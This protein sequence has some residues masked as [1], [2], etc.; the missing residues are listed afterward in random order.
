MRTCLIV[1]LGL[2]LIAPLGCTKSAPENADVAELPDWL[3]E[4]DGP[5]SRKRASS[6]NDSDEEFDSAT[7]N[8]ESR[9]KPGKLELKLSPGDRFP[10]TKTVDVELAQVSLSGTPEISRRRLELMLLIEVADRRADRTQLRVRYD[11]SATPAKWPA[12]SWNTIRALPRPRFRSPCGC[13]TTWFATD[14]PSG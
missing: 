14:S 13:I 5:A 10:L 8:D 7:A 4:G 2:L 11:R 3:D 6:K 1:L 12:R 9:E